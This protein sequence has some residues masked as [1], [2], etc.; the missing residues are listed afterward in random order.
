MDLGIA[1]RKAIVC[2]A[3]RGLGN[4]IANALA[5]EGVHLLMCARDRAVLDRAAGDIRS[6]FGVEV[7]T[8][9]TD[10]SV[11]AGRTELLA[12][13]AD[14]DILIH[15]GAWPADKPDY[16]RWTR[17]DWDAALDAMMMAPIDLIRGVVEGMIERRFGRIV[18]VTSR[19]VK[20]PKLEHALSVSPRLGLAGYVGGLARE[21]APHNVTINALLPG[22]FETETQRAYGRSLATAAGKPLDETW[23]ARESTNAARRFGK[24]EEFASLCAWLCSAQAGFITGQNIVMDGGGYP[25]V[26]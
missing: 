13:C 23:A 4:A 2:G 3:S 20:E 19:F 1:G 11:P 8:V 21:I 10:L 17:A 26:L 18:T 25:G 6:R 5:A 12:A 7:A 22:I 15:N 16:R 14:P 24:P 9:A